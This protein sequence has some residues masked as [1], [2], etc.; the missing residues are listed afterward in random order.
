M[1]SGGTAIARCAGSAAMDHEA[2]DTFT[3]LAGRVVTR[4][5]VGALAV[6]LAGLS[7]IGLDVEGKKKKKKKKKKTNCNLC[8]GVCCGEGNTCVIRGTAGEQCVPNIRTCTAEDNTCKPSTTGGLWCN[9]DANCD[10]YVTTSGAVACLGFTAS[11]SCGN[12]TKDADCTANYGPGSACVQ[13]DT[14]CTQTGC[15]QG[16]CK[17]ACPV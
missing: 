6:G 4:R 5:K 17:R 13:A 16:F 9:Y 3:R 14:G 2:F 7:A 12:C 15:K 11:T 10:C 1:D 8:G